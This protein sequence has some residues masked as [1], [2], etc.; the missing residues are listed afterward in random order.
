MVKYNLSFV[1]CM[2]SSLSLYK[3]TKTTTTKK[4][5]KNVKGI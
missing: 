3:C 4:R 1:I 2:L 5:S